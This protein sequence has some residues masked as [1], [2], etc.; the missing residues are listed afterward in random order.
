MNAR[1]Q[2]T[3]F[4]IGLAI[5]IPF[6]SCTADNDQIFP[7]PIEFARWDLAGV[8]S[9]ANYNSTY[10]NGYLMS[11]C[12]DNHKMYVAMSG[13]LDTSVHKIPVMRWGV[14][15][16]PNTI[17]FD[18]AH[19][20]GTDYL[21]VGGDT[22]YLEV[23][24][25]NGSRMDGRTRITFMGKPIHLVKATSAGPTTERDSATNGYIYFP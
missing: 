9:V 8:F 11:Y 25:D 3:K 22:A 1:E 10:Q 19:G 16:L 5:L 21:S 23:V 17:S 20:V 7:T 14:G 13:P 15:L 6:A 12:D 18:F 4:A 2:L 24:H